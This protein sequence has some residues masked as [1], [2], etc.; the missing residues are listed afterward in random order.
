M[1][2]L[3]TRPAPRLR[4]RA[5]RRSWRASSAVQRQATTARVLTRR[6][7][8]R[9]RAGACDTPASVRCARRQRATRTD[10]TNEWCA[11]R[12]GQAWASRQTRDCQDNACATGHRGLAP[13]QTQGERLFPTHTA[14]CRAPE[15]RS[16][17]RQRLD[18]A[19][20]DKCAVMLF[21]RSARPSAP[22]RRRDGAVAAVFGPAWKAIG[23][24]Q[25]VRGPWLAKRLR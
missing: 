17:T 5:P 20:R 10:R 11:P 24:R 19:W 6:A 7:R 25:R 14:E 23:F 13:V 22:L 21:V 1:G 9:H 16:L 12:P 4:Q 15:G 2:E 8:S 18:T 3:P